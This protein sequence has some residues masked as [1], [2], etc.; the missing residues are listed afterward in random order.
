M[1]WFGRKKRDR[2]PGEHSV[3]GVPTGTEIIHNPA[4]GELDTEVGFPQESELIERHGK[5]FHLVQG[6]NRIAIEVMHFVPRHEHGRP[7]LVRDRTVYVLPAETS[8]NEARRIG[9]DLLEKIPGRYPRSELMPH[10]GE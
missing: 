5:R 1:T 2:A 6:R 3:S 7:D 8:L 9:Y 10:S 4:S